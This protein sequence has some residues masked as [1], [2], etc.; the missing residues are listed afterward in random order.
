MD[1]TIQPNS[2]YNSLQ[3]AYSF[4][5]EKIFD[6]TL[7]DCLITLQRKKGAYGYFSPQRFTSRS[8]DNT[9]DEIALNPN[10]FEGRSDKEILSTLV[11][12]MAHVWQAHH[13]KPG[14]GGYHNKQWA[15]KMVS[16]G[17]LPLSDNGKGT[18]DKVSH[19][20][21][22]GELFDTT[23]TELIDTA[24]FALAWQDNTRPAAKKASV[25]KLKYSCPTCDLNIWGK[26]GLSVV[27]GECQEDLIS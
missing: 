18:G 12:E 5:N 14:R 10:L 27:C 16:I 20:I 21:A 24:K 23:A 26:P 9:T 3:K 7:P 4:F 17:L 19:T 11:H 8:A 22:E 25:S 13:G 15:E 6:N 2:E 1:S